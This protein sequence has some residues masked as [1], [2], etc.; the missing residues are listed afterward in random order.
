MVVP[1]SPVKMSTLK[2]PAPTDDDVEPSAK[3]VKIDVLSSPSKKQR[4][5]EDGII[6]MDGANDRLEEDDII[7]I[8]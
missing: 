1:D 7:V 6:M 3:R 8:D 2:R 4:L 5:E